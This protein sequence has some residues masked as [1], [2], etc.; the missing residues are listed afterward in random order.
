MRPG[1][2][3]P[4]NPWGPASPECSDHHGFNEARANSPGKYALL[5]AV[6]TLLKASMR[7]GPIRP[8]KFRNPYTYRGRP[9]WCMRASMRPG[10]IRPGILIAG[11]RADV[12]PCAYRFN[13]ARANSPGKYRPSRGRSLCRALDRIASM[14][15]GLIRPGNRP[16]P[17]FLACSPLQ[18]HSRPLRPAGTLKSNV[19]TTYLSC[20]AANSLWGN[21]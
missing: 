10:P 1:P 6:V 17:K 11:C 9:G 8:G 13:E 19:A 5:G 3:R 16:C 12:D 21:H 18:G 4:G 7:P 14:R 2:I 15:P 20:Q